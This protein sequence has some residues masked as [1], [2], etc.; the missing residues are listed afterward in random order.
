[1]IQLLNYPPNPQPV[2]FSELL[3]A[4]LQDIV[5]KVDLQSNFGIHHPDY[6]PLEVPAETSDRF[7]QLPAQ[8][9]NKFFRNYLCRFLY[10][11]YYNGALRTVLARDADSAGLA[12]NQNLENNTFLGVDQTFY[13]QAF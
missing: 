4:S 7:Q 11:I 10:G 6:Q 9:Q 1:M 12:V 3:M 2:A 5:S 8:F 13:G